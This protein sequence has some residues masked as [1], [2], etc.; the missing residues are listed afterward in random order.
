[1]SDNSRLDFAATLR[2]YVRRTPLTYEELAEAADLPIDT[3]LNWLKGKV[4]RPRNFRDV[5]KVARALALSASQT[6]RLLQASGH[7]PLANLLRFHPSDPTLQPW[8]GA[9]D[10]VAQPEPQTP[11]PL[12][13]P[14]AQVAAAP[15]RQHRP[16]GRGRIYIALGILTLALVL[17]ATWAANSA[18]HSSGNSSTPIPPTSLLSPQPSPAGGADWY[19]IGALQISPAYTSSDGRLVVRAGQAITASLRLRNYSKQTAT[20]D[21]LAIGVRGPDACTYL[22]G[23]PGKDFP[24]AGPVTVPPGQ[25]YIYQE[26]N[27]FNI[28]GVYFVEPVKLEGSWGG[29]PPYPRRWFSVTD[30]AGNLP[31]RECL[32]PLPNS[33][34]SAGWGGLLSHLTL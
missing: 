8:H 24:R 11:V 32:T 22:W 1:M 6:D 30:A 25:D 26:T 31:D 33:E 20:L 28:P 13:P 17:F 5:A 16:Q 4:R 29:I 3:L 18:Q 9:A 2:E 10:A 23:A 15:N 19:V 21:E 12:V 14:V 7:Q 34:S 27:D